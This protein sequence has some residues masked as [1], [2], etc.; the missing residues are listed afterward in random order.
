M[1]DEQL[2]RPDWMSEERWAQ[3][4]EYQRGLYFRR[5]KWSKAEEPKE[6]ENT[7]N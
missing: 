3:L 7:Q 2:K 5:G 6:E 1:A 4:T